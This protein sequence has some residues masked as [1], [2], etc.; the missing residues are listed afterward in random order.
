MPFCSIIIYFHSSRKSNLF[1][2]LR[3]LQER[4]PI[5]LYQL[6]LI[7]QDKFSDPLNFGFHDTKLVCLDSLDYRKPFMCNTGVGLAS[8]ENIVILD[9]D[10]ILPKNYIWSNVYGLDDNSLITSVKLYSL[11]KDYSDSDIKSGNLK[12][13][14]DFKSVSNRI[15]SKNMFSGNTIMKKTDYLRMGGMDENYVG[16]GF[17]DNDMTETCIRGGMNLI[18][19]ESIELHLH[20]VKNIFLDGVERTSFKDVCL[21]NG[22][23]YCSK[24]GYSKT[25]L[26]DLLCCGEKFL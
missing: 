24:W 6:I 9:C 12:M 22:L 4:E 10:R 8:S 20:H 11:S 14:P 19:N 5:Q 23:Y 7:C 15:R 17:A 2:Q 16:Y 26:G 13:I 1:Q 25:L 18:Y 21:K 3:F